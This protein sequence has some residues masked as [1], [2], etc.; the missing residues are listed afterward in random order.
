VFVMWNKK[1]LGLTV[2]GRTE[3]VVV[4]A[5]CEQRLEGGEH[6]TTA[7]AQSIPSGND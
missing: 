3:L 2:L 1:R 5:T 4:H 7:S 6:S